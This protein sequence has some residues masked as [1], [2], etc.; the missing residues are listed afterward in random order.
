MAI[1]RELPS[2]IILGKKIKCV[3]V[4]SKSKIKKYSKKLTTFRNY[5]KDYFVDTKSVT[6]KKTEKYLENIKKNESKIMYLVY[7][8]KKIVGQYGVHIW[9]NG[10]IS[11][12]GAMRISNIGPK[13]LFF[14]LQKKILKFLKK[15]YPNNLPVIICHKK[16]LTALKLHNNFKFV[17]IRDKNKLKFFQNYITKKKNNINNFYL[18]ECAK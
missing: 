16:N 6:F 15:I 18:K 11:L 10:Y 8:E 2:K 5:F 4:N 1:S 17:K 12:D 9:Q 13:D 3:R 7:F 14:N